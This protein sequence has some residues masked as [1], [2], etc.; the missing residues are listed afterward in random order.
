M[1]LSGKIDELALTLKLY[2]LD[3][4]TDFA[5]KGVQ[6]IQNKFKSELILLEGSSISI[7]T[8]PIKSQ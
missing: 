8:I 4:A 2:L 1:K 5:K 3:K 7:E 6:A